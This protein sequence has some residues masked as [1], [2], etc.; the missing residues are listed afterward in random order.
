MSRGQLL[1]MTTV[2]LACVLAATLGH[3]QSAPADGMLVYI[4]TYTRAGS[5]GIY[6][7]RF[8]DRSGVLRPLGLAAATSNPSFLAVHPNGRW[9]YAVNEDQSYQGEK[10]GA[11][12]AFAIDRVTGRLTLLN[13]QPS[14][15][16]DPC[17]ISI[18]RTGRYVLIA[19]YTGVQPVDDARPPRG[20]VAVLPIEPDGRLRDA[21]S[22]YI[23]FGSSVNQERQ[24]GP[25]AHAFVVDE[26]NR[27]AIATD[28]GTDELMVYRFDADHGSLRVVPQTEPK[29]PRIP[30]GVALPPG[31][32]PRHVAFAPSGRRL[33]AIN[34]L[35]SSITTFGWDAGSGVLTSE[36]TIS[37]LP[38]GFTGAN[39]TA[40]IAIHPSGRFLYG[41]NRGHDSIAVFRVDPAGGALT[42][43]EHEPSGGRTPRNF[44]I[45]PGG[46]WLVAANQD[47]N[48]LVVFRIDPQTG[49]LD[50][51]GDPATVT[52]PVCVTFVPDA[53][54]RP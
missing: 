46:H 37:T 8:D 48:S 3:G 5:Q 33:Y 27:F 40:E 10:T 32:G 31:S 24:A 25:H 54:K 52:L 13:Q 47:S 41:S 29:D 12:S 28:L 45:A 42:L 18:D 35:A 22:V 6:A 21:T 50:R 20:S 38:P 1:M 34:E 7:F 23:H 19:N 49:A 9:L 51:A 11:V 4:G 15:G 2:A 14:H 36:Q 53:V 17:H 26:T 44:A 43:V 39:T 16:A 30:S